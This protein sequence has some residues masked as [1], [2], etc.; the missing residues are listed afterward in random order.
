M[1][2]I[3]EQVSSDMLL[4]GIL[5]SL[6]DDKAEDVVSIN[7]H[8]KSEMADFMVIASGRSS[9]QVA[10]ISEK[11]TER[12]KEKFGTA[13]K[14]EGKDAGDWVLIDAGDIIVH[15][16]R[17]EVREFYQLEKMWMDPGEAVVAKI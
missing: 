5:S 13:C 10:S 17:P 4:E 11:L 6:E 15:V 2:D 8:G 3:P 1:T 9:R 14:V 12:L 7:L 16:F